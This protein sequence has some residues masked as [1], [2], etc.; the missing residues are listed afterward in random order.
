MIENDRMQKQNEEVQREKTPNTQ[1]A[2]NK[3]I[4]NEDALYKQLAFGAMVE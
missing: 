3:S 4:K 1:R 2:F